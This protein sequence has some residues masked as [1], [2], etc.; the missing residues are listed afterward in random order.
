MTTSQL[1]TNTEQRLVS[2]KQLL[3]E[4]GM[5]NY[6]TWYK[7]TLRYFK[8]LEESDLKNLTKERRNE[9]E[10]LNPPYTYK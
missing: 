9:K 7:Y 1:I 3:K 8:S 4:A 6:P 2:Y 10:G 5:N